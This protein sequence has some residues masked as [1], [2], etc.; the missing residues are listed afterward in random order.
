VAMQD[1][2]DKLGGLG[3]LVRQKTA[4]I[5]INLTGTDFRPVF[6]RPAGES[7]MTHEAT[8]TA[9][10]QQLF[11]AGAQRVRLVESTNRAEPLEKTLVRAGWDVRAMSALGKVEFENTRNMGLSKRYSQL[12]VPG[13][14]FLFSSFELNHS[15]EDTD[16]LI[17]LAKLKNHAVAGVTLSMKNL[18]GI[19]PNSLYGDDAPNETGTR[20]RGRLH[21]PQSNGGQQGVPGQKPGFSSG[22]EG[23]RIPRIVADLCAARP[24]HLAVIDGI[25]SMKGGEGP[26]NGPC[27]FVQPGLLAVGLNAVAADAVG[28]AVMGYAHVRAQR[29]TPPFLHGDN[30]LVLAERS[31]LG[32]ADLTGIEVL[33]LTVDQARFPY[34]A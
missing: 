14:G 15:F 18:F 2:L 7:F 19:T 12:K 6:R 10:M 24:I 32:P 20:G 23:Y 26:W 8:A 16:V 21:D 31:G 5:K 1:C 34:D 9:L 3:S 4:T 29:A 11:A 33:G 27:A 13:G 25:T 30:H 28:T 17:S 22:D